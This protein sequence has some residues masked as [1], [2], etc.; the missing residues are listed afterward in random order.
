MIDKTWHRVLTTMKCK[1]SYL[2]KR[3]FSSAKESCLYFQNIW[4]YKRSKLQRW[5]SRI[6][7]VHYYIVVITITLLWRKLWIIYIPRTSD[8]SAVARRHWSL[9]LCEGPTMCANLA[10][11][12]PRLPPDRTAAPWRLSRARWVHS[13]ANHHSITSTSGVFVI[14]L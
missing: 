11:W 4:S 1:M 5:M 6:V 2:E 13:P 8:K 14:C 9:S 7:L 3:T 10:R 12:S